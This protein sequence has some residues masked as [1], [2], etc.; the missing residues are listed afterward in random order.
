[1]RKNNKTFKFPFWFDVNIQQEGFFLISNFDLYCKAD[2]LDIKK[3]II[4]VE[5]DSFGNWVLH[6]K[7][8]NIKK[9]LNLYI[10]KL[11]VGIRITEDVSRKLVNNTWKWSTCQL[12]FSF[13]FSQPCFGRRVCHTLGP[14]FYLVSTN[15]LWIMN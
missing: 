15:L 3:I 8:L 9:K 13:N 7:F 11:V 1:M 4:S 12:T 2:K 14:H 5:S 10:T 6:T